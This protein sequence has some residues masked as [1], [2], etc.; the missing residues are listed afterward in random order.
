MDTDAQMARLLEVSVRPSP[1][2][3]KD[4]EAG[5]KVHDFLMAN[6]GYTGRIYIKKLLELGRPAIYSMIQEQS[7]TFR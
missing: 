3:T 7:A 2:F 5:R 4:S 1:L 6:Y